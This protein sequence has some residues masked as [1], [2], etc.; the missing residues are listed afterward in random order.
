MKLTLEDIK[1][2]AFGAVFV[3][4]SFGAFAFRRFTKEQAELYVKR[5]IDHFNKTFATAGVRLAFK[6]DASRMSFNYKFAFGSSRMYGWFDVYENDVLTAHIGG[7]GKLFT[8]GQA[9]IEFSPGEKRV[10]IYFPWSKAAFLSDV[11]L[12]GEILSP[13][14]RSRKMIC[15]GDSITHGYDAI[16]PSLAYVSLLAK[17]LDADAVNKGIGGDCFF[18]ELAAQ[19]DPERPDIVTAAYGTNDWCNYSRE[20]ANSGCREF[21]ENLCK[22]YPGAKIFAVTPI[23][24]KDGDKETKYGLPHRELDRVMRGLLAGLPVTVLNGYELTPHLPE[25]YSD[26]YLHPNDLGFTFYAKNLARMMNI[27]N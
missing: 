21:F 15:Y 2:I 24:R 26:G 6:T 18:P 1:K 13:C 12:D 14:P 17:A 5:N 8:S 20:H 7:E 19:P 11:E 9:K 4:E 23:W 10:E 16:Y 22:S 3:E 25:F 27:L